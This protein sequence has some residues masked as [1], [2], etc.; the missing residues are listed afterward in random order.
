M[1]KLN[2]YLRLIV[3]LYIPM[4]IS[5]LFIGSVSTT[6]AFPSFSFILGVIS[7]S[8]LIGGYNAYNAIID[9]EIDRINKPDRPLPKGT[10]TE[11]DAL[12]ASVF[13]YILSILV[14]FLINTIFL[15]LILFTAGLTIAYSHPT[16]HLKRKF[17]WG[18]LSAVILYTVLAPLAGWALYPYLEIPIPVILFLF[19]LGLPTGIMKDYIDYVGDSFH[20]VHSV[21]VQLGYNNSILVVIL[22]YML[23]GIFLFFLIY[24]KILMQKALLLFIIYPFMFINL[25]NM[26]KNYASNLNKDT[27]FNV[28]MALFI[29]TEITLS[30]IFLF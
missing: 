14:A 13:C 9:K 7:F 17:L 19:F 6:Y 10:L 26:P 23:S 25:L 11:K 1:S 21:P 20:K 2:E 22:L 18:T 5:G 15:L 30:A 12:Y 4:A 29:S 16:I 24:E 8:L 3:P 27:I 28:G